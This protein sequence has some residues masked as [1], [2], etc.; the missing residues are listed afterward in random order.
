MSRTMAVPKRKPVVRVEEEEPADTKKKNAASKP[1]VKSSS[2]TTKTK[3]SSSGQRY[4]SMYLPLQNEPN[5]KIAER[6][7]TD[8]LSILLAC[9]IEQQS[10]CVVC[11][12]I[13]QFFEHYQ[14][15]YKYQYDKSLGQY[16]HHLLVK[17]LL[18]D[19][20]SQLAS[21]LDQTLKTQYGDDKGSKR[22]Q[23]N[24]SPLDNMVTI[25]GVDYVPMSLEF[26]WPLGKKE[27]RK[28]KTFKHK[29]ERVAYLQ[30]WQ[31]SQP[32]KL[33]W[34]RLTDQFTVGVRKTPLPHQQVFLNRFRDTDWSV[35]HDP[36]AV[37]WSM[38]SG[39]TKGLTYLT[40]EGVHTRVIVVCPNTMINYWR[41]EFA[42]LAQI[43]DSKLFVF[44]LIVKRLS[45][46]FFSC[47]HHI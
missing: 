16:G 15:P 38:G 43:H 45:V 12:I 19:T 35:R 3:N 6:I 2:S 28:L 31:T 32:P 23:N 20:V 18:T 37:K 27:E 10:N 14:V 7:A 41:R 36:F 33:M 11:S 34:K 13:G 44:V 17:T 47:R 21:Y 25:D 46:I 5:H 42:S 30:Q 40:Q 39:K 26:L 29:Q 22:K 4:F 9:G 24:T 1:R 8:K